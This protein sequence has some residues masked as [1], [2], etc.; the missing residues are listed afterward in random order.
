[1]R[2]ILVLLIFLQM[3]DWVLNLSCCKV[4]FC[5]AVNGSATCIAFLCI[6]WEGV[7]VE[8]IGVH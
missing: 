7:C 1:M 4:S 8:N 6:I 2:L 3:I 5:M